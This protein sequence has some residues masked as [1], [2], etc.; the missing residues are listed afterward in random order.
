MSRYFINESDVD[1]DSNRITVVGENHNHLVN[2]L[3]SKI[4]DLLVLCDGTRYEYESEILEIDKSV[5]TV[6]ILKKY[7]STTEPKTEVC[8]YQGLPKGDKMEQIIQKSVELGVTKIVPV[9]CKRTVVKFNSEK[10]EQKKLD[11]WRKIALEASKQ[12]NRSIVPT[13]DESID[14]NDAILSAANYA[15]KFIP[16]EEEQSNSLKSF[17]D[18]RLAAEGKPA[19]TAFFIGPEGGFEREEVEFAI[20]NGFTPVTLGKRI[21]R[22]ETAGPTV[23]GIL[24]YEYKD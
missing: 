3:R 4:G 15:T 24:R 6:S 7:Y 23:V 2:V 21:L 20:N 11:R 13:I 12:C 16:Y 1:I 9:M 14:F 5:V 10:L 22:T 17:L 19:G 18:E 8:L